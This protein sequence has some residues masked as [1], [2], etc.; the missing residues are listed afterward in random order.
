MQDLV[1]TP[2]CAIRGDIVNNHKKY[3]SNLQD[4][5]KCRHILEVCSCKFEEKI[6]KEN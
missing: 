6:R 3:F 4:C 1:I 5:P 2:L